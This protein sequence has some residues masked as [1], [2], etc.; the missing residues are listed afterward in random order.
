MNLTTSVVINLLHNFNIN[1]N[2]PYYK[3]ANRQYNPYVKP[4]LKSA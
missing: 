3:A 1:F 4:H 2:L